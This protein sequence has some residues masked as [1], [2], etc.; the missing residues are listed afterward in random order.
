M[1]GDD[2]SFGK[3]RTVVERSSST[4]QQTTPQRT[5]EQAELDRLSL[6][7]AR[8]AQP[9]LLDIQGTGLEFGAEALREAL[10]ALPTLSAGIDP[11]VTGE[12][13]G[14]SLRDLN[15]RLQQ[16]GV[17]TFLESGA[18]QEAGVR[19]AGDIRRQVE[20]SNLNRLLNL[21]NIAVGGQAQ[22]QQPISGFQQQFGQRL[23]AVTR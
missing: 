23:S 12:I 2:M 9:G 11:N 17:G 7:Q 22:I 13:V 14:E 21:Q 5:P 16:S 1:G 8:A 3:E 18:A 10:A 15:A 20:E 4:Q 6:E 19:T